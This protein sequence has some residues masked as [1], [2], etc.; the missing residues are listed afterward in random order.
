MEK[1]SDLASTLRVRLELFGHEKGA[2]TGAAK[3]R[4]GKFELAHRG[5]IFL[6][7]IGEL[8][9]ELQ[10]KLLRVLQEKEIERL[11]SNHPLP[12]DFRVIAATNRDLY[13]EVKAGN[14][15][16]DLY[17][18]LNIFPIH[19]PPLRDREH[20]IPL[21]AQHFAGQFA[22]KT[23]LPFQG[24]SARTIDRLLEYR[25]PGNVRELQNL[26]ERAV[27][28]QRSPIVDLQPQQSTPPLS[29]RNPANGKIN[30]AA[31]VGEMEAV[32]MAYIREQQESME[33]LYILKVLEKT[34]WRVRGSSGA[35]EILNMKP[36]ALEYHMKKLGIER[37]GK[38]HFADGA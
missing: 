25:W 6:D 8:P 27:I 26:I 17:Y 23:G 12:L 5:T 34:R 4:V 32:D 24:F 33:R 21:L 28:T 35:A 29:T 38:S 11:G 36:N 9:L 20:D 31:L 10:A 19:L 30:I 7:E 15:R 14:F 16:V 1:H 37:K 22:H 3:E 18:R 13:A 2:F